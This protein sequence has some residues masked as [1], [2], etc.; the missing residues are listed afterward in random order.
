MTPAMK[1]YEPSMRYI[2]TGEYVPVMVE[3][4]DGDCVMREDAIAAIDAARLEEMGRTRKLTDEILTALNPSPVGID[5]ERIDAAFSTYKEESPDV[6]A[7][8]D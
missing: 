1:R 6:P 7:Q 2:G 3:A 5:W 8:Q 4:D